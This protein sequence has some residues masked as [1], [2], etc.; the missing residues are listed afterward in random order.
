L[1][2]QQ[3]MLGL[4][5]LEQQRRASRLDHAV[6]DLGHLEMRVD[7]GGDAPKLALALEQRDPF[8]QVAGRRHRRS[9]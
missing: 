8:A 1:V 4:R 6:D 7:L 5:V 9:V 2:D 3:R